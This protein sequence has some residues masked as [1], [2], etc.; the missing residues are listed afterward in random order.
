MQRRQ[1]DF[2]ER[3][4]ARDRQISCQYRALSAFDGNLS[5]FDVQLFHWFLKAG[6]RGRV[7]LIV[8]D[9][10]GAPEA[11]LRVQSARPIKICQ[12]SRFARAPAP[13]AAELEMT[14]FKPDR[15]IDVLTRN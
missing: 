11:L 8:D 12:R 5:N 13:L 4:R 7:V 3:A 1:W 15:C 9:L 14:A 2:K 10:K 6:D